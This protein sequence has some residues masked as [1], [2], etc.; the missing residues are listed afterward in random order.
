MTNVS[1]EGLTTFDRILEEAMRRTPFDQEVGLLREDAWRS[2][3][4]AAGIESD[5]AMCAAEPKAIFM[6]AFDLATR[7]AV[8]RVLHILAQEEGTLIPTTYQRIDDEF[9]LSTR[10]RHR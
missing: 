6:H 1:Q 9:G 2:Y 10:G 4:I 3:A 8:G 5:C 7:E